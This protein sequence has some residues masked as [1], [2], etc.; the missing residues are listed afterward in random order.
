MDALP[1][2]K[3]HQRLI[4]RWLHLVHE[5]RAGHKSPA[6]CPFLFISPPLIQFQFS[7]FFHSFHT[8]AGHQI[9]ASAMMDAQIDIEAAYIKTDADLVGLL[10]TQLERFTEGDITLGTEE[11][12]QLESFTELVGQVRSEIKNSKKKRAHLILNDL[13]T[14]NPPAFFLCALGTEIHKLSRLTSRTYMATVMNWWKRDAIDR[15]GLVKTM[16]T[17]AQYLPDPASSSTTPPPLLPSTTMSLPMQSKTA[18][19]EQQS[20]IDRMGVLG[21]FM[22]HISDEEI[23]VMVSHPGSAPF[24]HFGWDDWEARQ[25]LS[26]PLFDQYLTYRRS[27]QAMTAAEDM[28]QG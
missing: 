14:H 28:Q 4:R 2:Q 10:T 5:I 21:S 7:P 6:L 16:K 11:I 17:Y 19:P 12:E 9:F 8:S 23:T 26:K 22:D 18:A 1:L 3:C 24:T 13:L 25:Y 15:S 27:F 20:V